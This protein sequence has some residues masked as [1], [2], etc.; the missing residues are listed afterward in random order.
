M[1]PIGNAVL[2]LFPRGFIAT[3]FSLLE[4]FSKGISEKIASTVGAPEIE[5]D[6]SK[7]IVIAHYRF[8]FHSSKAVKQRS[9][10]SDVAKCWYFN[11][12]L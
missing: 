7:K 9:K 1:T 10:L 12:D 3:L 5:R 6:R 8:A 4:D 11:I 2:P